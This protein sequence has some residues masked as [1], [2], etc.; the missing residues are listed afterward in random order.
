MVMPPCVY[1]AS[2][3]SSCRVVLHDANAR[4]RPKRA[5]TLS[6]DLSAATSQR[7]PLSG[8]LSAATYQRRP[9]S[10]DSQRWQST[11]PVGSQASQFSVLAQ[12]P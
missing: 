2:L 3:E 5:A 4:T 6:G 1:W 8:D 12:R 7:R 11:R 9:I 10:G